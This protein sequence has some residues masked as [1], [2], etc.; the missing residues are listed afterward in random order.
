[1]LGQICG[2]I[3]EEGFRVK[4][5]E[6]WSYYNANGWKS[7]GRPVT[8]ENCKSILAAWDARARAGGG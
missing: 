8:K 4:A 5:A 3:E 2:F 1:M 6:F 7:G